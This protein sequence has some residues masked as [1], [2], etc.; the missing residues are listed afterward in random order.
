VW[1]DGEAEHVVELVKVK[2]R[3]KPGPCAFTISVDS[4]V[5]AEATGM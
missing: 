3:F 5:V 4:T 1:H 2:P